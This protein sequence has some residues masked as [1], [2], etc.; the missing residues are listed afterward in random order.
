MVGRLWADRIVERRSPD[1]AVAA[2][3][4]TTAELPDLRRLAGWAAADDGWF[5]VLHGEVL[6]R[7]AP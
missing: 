2:A 4:P 5:A 3:T 1:Q 7:P 6:C